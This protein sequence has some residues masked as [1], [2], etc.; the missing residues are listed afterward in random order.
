MSLP[1]RLLSEAA[2]LLALRGLAS[3][4]FHLQMLR[5]R[6]ASVALASGE[7]LFRRTVLASLVL[8][9][10]LVQEAQTVKESVQ[11][12]LNFVLRLGFR[13]LQLHAVAARRQANRHK[14]NL[15]LQVLRHVKHDAQRFTD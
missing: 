8:D 7:V 11:F 14:C 10:G 2:R 3:V 1:L 15:C 13:N 5:V 12:R 4:G 6:V 9:P